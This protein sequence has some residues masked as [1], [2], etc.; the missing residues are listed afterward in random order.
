MVLFRHAERL[1]ER[2]CFLLGDLIIH[3]YADPPREVVVLDGVEREGERLNLRFDPPLRHEGFHPDELAALAELGY[4]DLS[5]RPDG[6]YRAYVT[7]AGRDYFD[8]MCALA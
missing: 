7:R 4:V 1:G 3:Q 5:H 8:D 6:D 2:H